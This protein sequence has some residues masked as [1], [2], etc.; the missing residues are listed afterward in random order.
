[1]T[2]E[3][4]GKVFGKMT[5]LEIGRPYKGKAKRW[6]CR[7]ECGNIRL[8]NKFQINNKLRTSCGCSAAEGREGI[9]FGKLLK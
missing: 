9:I 7:C 2:D 4:I 8:R 5:V 1:M 6:R 3:M